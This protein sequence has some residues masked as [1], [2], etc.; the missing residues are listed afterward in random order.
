MPIANPILPGSHPDPALIRVGDT[1]Y[2]AN[3]TF[4][5]WPP[6]N[7]HR[8]VDLRHWEP[9]PSPI[10]SFLREHASL[11]PDDCDGVWLRT[12]VDIDHYRYACSFDGVE[13]KDAGVTL[14]ARMLTDEH[15]EDTGNGFFTGAFV[16]VFATDM[17]GY[18]AEATF[19]EMT[20]ADGEGRDD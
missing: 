11:V 18:G 15:A 7:L 8:S 12:A 2:L 17:T 10:T 4:E 19:D 6:L 3:S 5:W 20:Y 9:L 16:G 14:D 1:Y 13:W